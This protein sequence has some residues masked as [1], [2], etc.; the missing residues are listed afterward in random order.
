[1]RSVVVFFLVGLLAAPGLA[2]T[3]SWPEIAPLEATV[4]FAD[5]SKAA[6]LFKILDLK[7]KP[8][9]ILQCYNWRSS[10]DPDFDYS[11]DFECRLT[12]TY[13]QE[14]HSTLLTDNPRQSRD[15]QSRAR[16]LA[17]ELVGDCANYPEYGRARHFRLRKMR[18]TFLFDDVTFKPFRSPDGR[19]VKR[20]EFE[21][22][23]FTLRVESDV[24]A[25]SA[26]AEPVPFAEPP[27]ANPKDPDD[28]TLDCD[29]ILKRSR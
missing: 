5:A 24:R 21:S 1:M 22:F 23:R 3:K 4:Y 26:I 25:L 10:R 2:Q 28:F 7:G 14:T 19:S 12:S 16:V 29:V 13:S 17:E 9:Y 6:I 27:R 20:R 18:I 15:W 8:L 11:G